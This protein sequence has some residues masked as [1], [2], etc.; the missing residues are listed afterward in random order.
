MES[1][2]VNMYN[3]RPLNI[4]ILHITVKLNKYECAWGLLWSIVVYCH[5]IVKYLKCT[6]NLFVSRISLLNSV[7]IS[8]ERLS[9]VVDG[10]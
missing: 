1:G 4:I 5:L 7:Q 8:I 2:D 10:S 9:N 6:S 3:D